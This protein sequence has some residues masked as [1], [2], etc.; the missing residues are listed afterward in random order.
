MKALVVHPPN[1]GV[2][3]KEISDIDRS[4]NGNEVL[5]KTIAN[6]ICGTDRGIVSGLLKFSRPPTEKNS[7]VLG[8]ENLG[9]VIDK[10][11]NVQGSFNGR[12]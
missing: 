12:N 3:V 11:S 10:G 7:L 1:K 4:L 6:G 5:I 9:Q 2:E 8:H